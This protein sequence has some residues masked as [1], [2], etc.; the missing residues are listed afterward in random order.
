MSAHE[1][2]KLIFGIALI[3]AGYIFVS[4]VILKKPWKEI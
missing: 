3:Y 2:T 1:Q 4:R